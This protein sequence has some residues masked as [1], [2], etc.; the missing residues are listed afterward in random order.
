MPID[1]EILNDGEMVI[2]TVTGVLIGQELADHM[3][4]Q[5]NQFGTALKTGYQQ[6]FDTLGADSV[7]IDE[8]DMKRISQIILTYGQE[9]GKVAT[10][11]VA[12][13]PDIRKMAYY[14]KS[15]SEITEV[16]VEVFADRFEAEEWLAG[17]HRAR[18]G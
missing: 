2:S 10:A 3:F 7:D 1:H 6:I 18:A 13:S 14:Y 8:E 9:R 17:L 15:L 4:W 5:I 16:T 12:I 11:I